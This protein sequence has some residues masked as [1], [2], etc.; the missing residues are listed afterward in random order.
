M[1]QASLAYAAT[2]VVRNTA[3]PVREPSYNWPTFWSAPLTITRARPLPVGGGLWQDFLVVPEEDLFPR[4][5][6]SYIATPFT[7]ETVEF[8]WVYR[9]H[10]LEPQAIVLPA[11]VSRHLRR[12]LAH[13]FPCLFRR[14]FVWAGD[15]SQLKIQAR[16]LTANQQLA[17]AAVFGWYYPSFDSPE[18]RGT[19]EGVTDAVRDVS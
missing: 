16:N 8:R 18:E 14:F 9:D 10:L 1:D 7:A 15:A 19:G 13:P 4:V 6:N 3:I 11:T 2:R 12:Q 17:F 5:I